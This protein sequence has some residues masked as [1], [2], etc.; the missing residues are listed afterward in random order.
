VKTLRAL[1][2]LFAAVTPAFAQSALLALFDV[3]RSSPPFADRVQEIPGGTVLVLP[4][5]DEFELEANAWTVPGG[6]LIHPR[7]SRGTFCSHRSAPP[8]ERTGEVPLLG[9]FAGGRE[10]FGGG[11]KEAD[12]GLLLCFLSGSQTQPYVS[13]VCAW[14]PGL[15]FVLSWKVPGPAL[16][17]G[18]LHPEAPSLYLLDARFGEP[19]L[20]SLDLR[21]G[22]AFPVE[23]GGVGP[24]VH[25]GRS[26]LR[27]R[28]EI[29]LGCAWS[30]NDPGQPDVQ[31][32]TADE[33]E[34]LGPLIDPRGY[35]VVGDAMTFHPQTG[36][37][38]VRWG[39]FLIKRFS[40]SGGLLAQIN[41]GFPVHYAWSGAIDLE[42]LPASDRFLA[43]FTPGGNGER[44]SYLASFAADFSSQE[45]PTRFD[46]WRLDN[47]QASR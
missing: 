41:L 12:G 31:R 45:T 15:P 11:W 27:V 9:Q 5:G 16:V 10:S 26:V 29:W 24:P 30:G 1:V 46:G 34:W 39:P 43:S 21:S 20:W 8:F 22:G 19:P 17:A 6:F 7:W 14:V 37:V 35:Q 44:H 40:R 36:D 2:L 32:Y 25:G 38:L 28:R 33:L 47:V 3:T 23:L 42:H 13:T 18:T 4:P